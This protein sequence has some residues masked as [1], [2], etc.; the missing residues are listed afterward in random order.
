MSEKNGKTILI[1]VGSLRC[2][3]AEVQTVDLANGLIEKG[4][5]VHL[6]VLEDSDELSYRLNAK[7]QLAVYQKKS[8]LD[9]SVVR[10]LAGLMAATRPNVILAC[11]SYSCMYAYYAR[12]K[13]AL[14]QIPLLCVNHMT[15]LSRKELF[16]T[17]LLYRGIQNRIQQNIFV[18]HAQKGYWIQHYGLREAGS[19]VIY[20]GLDENFSSD[21]VAPARLQ[22]LDNDTFLVGIVAGLKPVK[23][24]VDM[25]EAVAGLRAQ[26]LNI[27]AVFVGDGECREEIEKKITE[28]GSEKY[29]YMAGHQTDV[30]PY[31]SRINCFAL[32]S[33]WEALS[34]SAL[35]AMAMAKP[36]LLSNVGGAKELVGEGHNGYLYCARDIDDLRAKLRTLYESDS[37]EGMGENSRTLFL[38]QFTSGP[39]V[40]KYHKML[41]GFAGVHGTDIEEEYAQ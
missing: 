15:Y 18:C 21:T 9:R 11:E 26:G 29:V 22:G 12:G 31:L 4:W 35:E 40:E 25:V 33:D 36:L 6:A 5:N 3:G 19:A 37:L 24:H 34:I 10:E 32:T 8:F 28:L 7:I 16:K 20:N 39:M 27:S 13:A 14:K 23:R 41:C 1:V 2:G 17:L 30:K 38:Q